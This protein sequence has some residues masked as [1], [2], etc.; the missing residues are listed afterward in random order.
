MLAKLFRTWL[1]IFT[2]PLLFFFSLFL[3]LTTSSFSSTTYCAHAAGIP[4]EIV[5]ER[6]ILVIGRLRASAGTDWSLRPCPAFRPKSS[7]SGC[8][9]C[10]LAVLVVVLVVAK[11]LEFK[12]EENTKVWPKAAD[13][14]WTHEMK[15]GVTL[16][17]RFANVFV[18]FGSQI[19]LRTFNS[20]NEA[21]SLVGCAFEYTTW[22]VTFGACFLG[23]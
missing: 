10:L 12:S 1:P 14:K 13:S 4:S 17:V 21:S 2:L 19:W 18:L 5:A 20:T 8:W 3:L 6:T 23:L 15:W 9:Y 22:T 11:L 16:L 7:P